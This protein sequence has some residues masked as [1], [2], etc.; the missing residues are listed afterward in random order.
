MPFKKGK[1]GNPVGKPK[2]AK[3]KRTIQWESFSA[4]CMEGGLERFAQE[5]NTL[6]GKD[7]TNAFTNLLEFFKPKL[8]RTELTGEVNNKLEIIVTHVRSNS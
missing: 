3:D 7:Y 5:L 1:S 8:A 6:E 4:Y 2:G